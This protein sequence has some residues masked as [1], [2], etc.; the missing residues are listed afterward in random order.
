MERTVT[1]VLQPGETLFLPVGWWHHVVSLDKCMGA[2]FTNF[3]TGPSAV[4][5]KK[6]YMKWGNGAG[7]RYQDESKRQNIKLESDDPSKFFKP[8][9]SARFQ[10]VLDSVDTYAKVV[11][12]LQSEGT[13][14]DLFVAV[15]RAPKCSTVSQRLVSLM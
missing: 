15:L 11:T 8:A 6:M 2:S 1:E 9:M 13:F 10:E 5:E 14:T 12:T 7:S 3:E 4:A